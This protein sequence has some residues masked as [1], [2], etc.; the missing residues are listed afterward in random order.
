MMVVTYGVR[1]SIITLLEDKGMP[2]GINRALRYV[3]PVALAA[4]V[5]PEILMP[6][7]TLDISPMNTRLLAGIAAAVVAR[8][9]RNTILSIAV[10]MVLL[11]V[12]QAL[13]P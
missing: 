8:L 9:T 13:I 11:W 6:A 10:G 7:G 3:P 2:E 4:I 5:F 1:L 12:L